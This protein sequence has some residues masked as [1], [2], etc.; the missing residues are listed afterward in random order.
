MAEMKE[1]PAGQGEGATKKP[2]EDSVS[3]IVTDPKSRR[4]G[5]TV[6]VGPDAPVDV[7][8]DEAQR[9][10]ELLRVHFRLS[11]SPSRREYILRHLAGSTDADRAE[12][13]K[14][15]PRLYEVFD[16]CEAVGLAQRWK[17]RKDGTWYFT[18]RMGTPVDDPLIQLELE[19]MIDLTSHEVMS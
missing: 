5:W 7:Y 4:Y 2:A 10:G 17:D 18:M 3:Y 16:R 19:M 8:Y 15:F 12:A 14:V 9:T 1:A 11:R 13:M 6:K